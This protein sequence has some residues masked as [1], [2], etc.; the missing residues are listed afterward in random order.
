LVP[1]AMP[2]THLPSPPTKKPEGQ[3]GVDVQARLAA[4]SDVG[5]CGFLWSVRTVFPGSLLSVRTSIVFEARESS[6]ERAAEFGV[7]CEPLD[8][9]LAE[10]SDAEESPLEAEAPAE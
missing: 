3:A 7:A 9:E 8:D 5:F 6:A 2:L 10:A 1:A 4:T